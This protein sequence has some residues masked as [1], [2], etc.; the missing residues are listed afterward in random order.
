MRRL[1]R[2]WPKVPN[3]TMPMRRDVCAFSLADALVS[4]S[5]GIAASSAK[6]LQPGKAGTGLYASADD[7]VVW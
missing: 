5:K 2:N 7:A 3:P 4:K 6:T 1:A